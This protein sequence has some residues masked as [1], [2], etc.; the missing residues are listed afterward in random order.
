MDSGPGSGRRFTA[1]RQTPCAESDLL[2]AVARAHQGCCI[3]S[4]ATL[5]THGCPDVRELMK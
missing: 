3:L 4:N 5:Q 1:R 2:A